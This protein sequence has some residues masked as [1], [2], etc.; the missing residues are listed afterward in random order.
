MIRMAKEL[1]VSGAWVYNRH[2]R[3]RGTE[4]PSCICSNP[5][6]AANLHEVGLVVLE[7]TLRMLAGNFDVGETDGGIILDVMAYEDFSADIKCADCHTVQP[8]LHLE[9]IRFN[10][11]A[12]TFS[13]LEGHE[14]FVAS[15]Q[16]GKD[17]G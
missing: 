12:K 14:D 9:D 2:D 6:C 10:P 1:E 5:G 4:P 11:E 15:P 13:E 17:E 8:Q 3:K 16:G 7:G